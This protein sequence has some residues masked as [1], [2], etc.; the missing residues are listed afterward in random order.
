MRHIN[1]KCISIVIFEHH[2]IIP[3]YKTQNLQRTY[4]MEDL[5]CSRILHRYVF[6]QHSLDLVRWQNSIYPIIFS[7]NLFDSASPSHPRCEKNCTIIEYVDRRPKQFVF[8]SA[9]T[10]LIVMK[11]WNET[12]GKQQHIYASVSSLVNNVWYWALMTFKRRR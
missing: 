6:L 3:P 5:Y 11:I 9:L 10:H 2:L 7:T 8:V 1:T 4:D 12:T